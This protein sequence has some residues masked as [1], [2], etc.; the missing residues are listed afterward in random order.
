VGVAV[1]DDVNAARERAALGG[2]VGYRGELPPGAG[3]GPGEDDGG[4][5]F[6]GAGDEAAAD[7]GGAVV[8]DVDA[9]RAPVVQDGLEGGDGRGPLR[10]VLL[11]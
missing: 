6:A 5:L 10:V 11:A 8:E 3:A 9:G 7:G 4:E 1:L 2:G